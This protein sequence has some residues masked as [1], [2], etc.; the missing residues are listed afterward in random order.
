MTL[1]ALEQH[2]ML[3]AMALHPDAYGVSIGEYIRDRAGYEPSL[4]SIYATLDR[5]ESKGFLKARLGESTDQRGGKRKLHFTVTANGQ[6]TLRESLRA[7]SELRRGL[8]WN[9]ATS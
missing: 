7:V 2:V 6:A 8:R 4:G 9:E 5:L 3:A 1:S